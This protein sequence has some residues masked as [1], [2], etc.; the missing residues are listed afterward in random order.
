MP[1]RRTGKHPD[2]LRR[3]E[4]GGGLFRT[5]DGISDPERV[6]GARTYA[7]RGGE[8]LGRYLKLVPVFP[9]P[10]SSSSGGQGDAKRLL[11]GDNLLALPDDL[12]EVLHGGDRAHLRFRLV[13]GLDAS[14]AGVDLASAFQEGI[15]LT[16]GIELV[17][18]DIL[19]FDS[20][21]DQEDP[22]LVLLF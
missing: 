19:E 7:S 8:R 9:S 16:D 3:A 1:D 13:P 14:A 22:D 6:W 21:T 12:I 10:G 20:L 18:T 2:R 4:A 11:E 5:C 17:R 15:G